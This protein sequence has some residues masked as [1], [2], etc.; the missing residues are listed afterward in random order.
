MSC[1]AVIGLVLCRQQ[2]VRCRVFNVVRRRHVD[3][4]SLLFKDCLLICLVVYC[5]VYVLCA[6]LTSSSAR[7]HNAIYNASRGKSVTQRKTVRKTVVMVEKNPWWHN[8]SGPFI[9]W[10]GPIGVKEDG[11]GCTRGHGRVGSMIVHR[12]CCNK[13]LEGTI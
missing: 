4:C 5:C 2:R 7:R 11:G 6:T 3:F 1:G 10:Q 12:A 8:V 9:T 13:D